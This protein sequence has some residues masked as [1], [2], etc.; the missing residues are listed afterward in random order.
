ME[1]RV[2]GEEFE[3]F[4]QNLEALL[5]YIVRRYVVDRNLQPFKS[6]AIEPLNALGDQHV[7]VR[8]EPSDHST[9]ANA[10]ND[11]VQLR[12]QKRF[13]TT[14]RDHRRAQFVQFVDSL[15]HSR[16]RNW[17]G[18]I[19][20]LIAIFA[21]QIASANWNDVRQQR[22]IRGHERASNHACPAKVAVQRKHAPT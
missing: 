15:E 19:V 18:K 20:V 22:M 2:L 12:M 11:L 4:I 21:G 1:I 8:N 14:D 7:A 17:L 9:F 10:T 3:F 6:R 13:A 5:G 16:S